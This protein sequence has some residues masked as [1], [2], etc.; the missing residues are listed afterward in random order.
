MAMRA[1][2]YV[3]R[4][5][6]GIAL[7][8]AVV[9]AGASN[10][11]PALKAKA[12]PHAQPGP[13]VVVRAEAVAGMAQTVRAYV[14]PAETAFVADFPHN[15]EVRIV[16]GK[17]PKAKRRVRFL[18]VNRGCLFFAPDQPEGGDRKTP[19]DYEIDAKNGKASLRVS[20]HAAEPAGTYVVYAEPVAKPG[21]RSVR[22][23]PFTLIS[24]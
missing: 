20:I 8:A 5:L 15:L 3:A 4:P 10:A 9:W 14:A 16:G 13:A 1:L 18:C 21:E 23:G 7:A 11:A 19:S 12:T 2:D 22:S 17:D 24:H 6:A